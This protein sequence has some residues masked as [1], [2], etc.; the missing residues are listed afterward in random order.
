MEKR[1][2]YNNSFKRAFNVFEYK[3]LANIRL[4]KHVGQRECAVGQQFSEFEF[5]LRDY[6]LVDIFVC[7]YSIVAIPY[8]LAYGR[9][10]LCVRA[11][12]NIIF[13]SQRNYGTFF[14]RFVN[15]WFLFICVLFFFAIVSHSAVNNHF[16]E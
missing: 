1:K 9:Y 15:F 4:T 7:V 3:K 8:I 16:E 12:V 5:N 14:R 6:F 13:D 10:A 11:I 2:Q